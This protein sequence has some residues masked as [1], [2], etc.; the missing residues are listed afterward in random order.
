MRSFGEAEGLVWVDVGGVRYLVEKSACGGGGFAEMMRRLEKSSLQCPC[1]LDGFR[2]RC[3][4]L[5]VRQKDEWEM[6]RS[7]VE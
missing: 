2:R 4:V 5:L 3:L 6:R 1:G 7:R